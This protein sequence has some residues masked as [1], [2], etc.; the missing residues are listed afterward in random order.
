MWHFRI[1][2]VIVYTSLVFGTPEVLIRMLCR[3]RRG[4]ADHCGYPLLQP[5]A[6]NVLYVSDGWKRKIHNRWKLCEVK[7]AL[8][9]NQL[10]GTELL[11]GSIVHCRL[12]GQNFVVVTDCLAP[13]L[14]VS[15]LPFAKK[16][17]TSPIQLG[18]QQ[19]GPQHLWIWE[20]TVGHKSR[21]WE[22]RGQ[23]CN[24]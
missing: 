10:I 1:P 8:Y 9:M 6:K 15:V 24:G 17:K 13:K 7:I 12:Q 21:W 11:K 16:T 3:V 2:F 19:W 22:L 23:Y 18:C 14:N 4:S 20:E 5:A